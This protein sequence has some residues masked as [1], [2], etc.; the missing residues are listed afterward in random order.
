MRLLNFLNEK[1]DTPEGIIK[2]IKKNCSEFLNL[3]DEKHP[4]FR[5][6][7]YKMFFEKIKVDKNRTPVDLDLT[8]HKILDMRI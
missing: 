2:T 4:L 7:K 8:N 1:D 3:T 6:I 5:G